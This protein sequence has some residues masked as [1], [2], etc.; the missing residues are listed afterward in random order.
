MEGPDATEVRDTFP[1]R[2]VL[3]GMDTF[4]G[5]ELVEGANMEIEGVL[6]AAEP[7]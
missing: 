5:K 4:G 6:G 1:G 7:P 2:G 3:E